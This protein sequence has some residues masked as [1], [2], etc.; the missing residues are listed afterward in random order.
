MPA[1]HQTPKPSKPNCKQGT[2]R[3]GEGLVPNT[4]DE[5]RGNRPNDQGRKDRRK[6]RTGRGAKGA[7]RLPTTNPNTQTRTRRAAPRDQGHTRPGDGPLQTNTPQQQECRTLTTQ[8]KPT[9]QPRASNRRTSLRPHPNDVWQPK[10]A[11]NTMAR[12][13]PLRPKKK[14]QLEALPTPD[15]QS[16]PTRNATGTPTNGRKW[17]TN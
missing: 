16:L 4:I 5:D 8:R 6:G 1:P 17:L 3:D 11:A 10:G 2:P 9:V 15:T 12:P 13:Q 14:T 7:R